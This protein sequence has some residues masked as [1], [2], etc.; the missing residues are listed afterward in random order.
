MAITINTAVN[1]LV[2]TQQLSLNRAEKAFEALSSGKQINDAADD[3]A[4]LAIANR[5][6]TQ[7]QGFF[8]AIESATG[9]IALAQTADKA[10]GNVTEGL[11]RIKQLALQSENGALDDNQRQFLT[12][13]AN[14]IR[15][16]LA[17]I[18][19]TTK[20]NDRN[21]LGQNDTLNFQVGTEA[22][23][24]LDIK[25][26]NIEE[27]LQN[28]GLA[29]TIDLSSSAD[30]EGLLTAIDTS[31]E[32]VTSKQVEFGTLQNSLSSSIQNL[33][34]RKIDS[35]AAKSRIEDTDFAKAVTELV[36]NQLQNEINISIQ[37]QANADKGL[38]SSL[39]GF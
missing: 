30:V 35:A 14:A 15:T 23:Q 17:R 1:T 19:E 31:L 21:I 28:A 5:L 27:T 26:S 13:E 9:G 22:S 16:E 6:G 12:D 18:A 24:T 39:L 7:N 33:S 34:Q 2:K 38:V 37:T 8:A 20:F 32:A 11:Q 10:L 4:G 3:A 29:S 25:T 36:K